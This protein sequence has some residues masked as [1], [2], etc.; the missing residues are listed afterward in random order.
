MFQR[1]QRC[2]RRF[3][4]IP[5]NLDMQITR[6]MVELESVAVAKAGRVSLTEPAVKPI[7]RIGVSVETNDGITGKGTTLVGSVGASTVK[8]LLETDLVPLLVG[9]DPR[10]TDALFT[11]VKNCCDSIGWAGI[12]SQAYAALDFALWEIKAKIAS[13]TLGQLL[14]GVRAEAP[15]FVSDIGGPNRSAGEVIRLA[16]PWIAKGAKGI[17]VEVGSG[18]VQADADR[19]R[20]IS[21]EFGD[22][23]WIGVSAEGR[24]DLATALALSHFFDDIGIGWFEYPLPLSDRAGYNRLADRMETILAA[25]SSCD[26]VSELI[27]MAKTGSVRVLRPDP[28]RLGGITPLLKLAPV[29]DACHCTMVPVR[30]PEIAEQ[31]AM[32]LTV[33]PQ[34]ER[35]TC[36]DPES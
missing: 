30:L 27:E 18:D 34:I 28:L 20:A 23:C 8:S 31:L 6:I 12:A 24:Y 36:R 32:G 1:S 33:V 29:A 5:H 2:S 35:V 15:F 16:K 25:G 3:R 26:S 4:V 22:D 17:R 7:Q 13:Q 9:E 19:V 11:K 21:D 10:R 14:G